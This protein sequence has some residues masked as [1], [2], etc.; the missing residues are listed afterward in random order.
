MEN[1]R[2][3][4]RSGSA[5]GRGQDTPENACRGGGRF[6]AWCDTAPE[7]SHTEG[8]RAGHSRTGQDI[9]KAARGGRLGQSFG[10]SEISP[11][12]SSSRA[13]TFSVCPCLSSS[14]TRAINK[15]NSFDVISN[16][17][18]KL[19]VSY[20]RWLA[21][22]WGCPAVYTADRLTRSIV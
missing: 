20:F 4:G 10:G 2:G 14:R 15:S 5:A 8:D 7:E 11:R 13:M 12:A 17:P 9:S 18:F 6:P 21:E 1:P 3:A 22:A 19:K 16:T